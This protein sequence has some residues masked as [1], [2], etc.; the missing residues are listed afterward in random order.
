MDD[1]AKRRKLKKNVKR[2][3]LLLFLL[4]V[5][6]FYLNFKKHSRDLSEQDVTS[7]LYSIV[8]NAESIA[9]KMIGKETSQHD[10]HNH[11]Y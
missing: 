5:V 2:A 3:M 7:L 11:S 1:M 6:L 10:T 4:I 9:R 8:D